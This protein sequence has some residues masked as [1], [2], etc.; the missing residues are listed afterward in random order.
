MRRGGR[1]VLL[2]RDLYRD[3]M[4]FSVS[5][6]AGGNYEVGEF[7]YLV[8]F[9]AQNRDLKAIIVIQMHVHTGESQ[10]MVIMLYRGYSTGEIALVM[11]I[12]IAEGGHAMTRTSLFQ[13]CSFEMFAYQV[14]HGF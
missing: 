12:D 11:I 2:L 1:R 10:V 8:N 7:F 5:H 4:Q 13:P 3:H 6:S 9:T 14:A